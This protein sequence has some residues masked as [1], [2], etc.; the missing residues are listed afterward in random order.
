[1]QETR[2][3]ASR[4]RFALSPVALVVASLL[5]PLAG[6]AQA[7]EA[8]P[9][10]KPSPKLR[11]DIPDAARNQLP[12]FVEGD[13]ISGQTDV[14]T[15]IEGGAELRRGDTV[16][17]ADRMEYHQSDDQARARGNVRINK[18]GNIFEGPLLE[19]KVDAF[20]GFFNEP[21]YRFLR[22]NAYGEADRVD[23]IDDKRAIIRNASYTTC[24]RKPGP[25]WMPDWILRAASI[26][27]DEEEET[28]QA[29]GA[30]LSFMGLPIL[31]VPTMSF[32]L[33]DKRKSGVLPPT[34][35][36]DNVSGIELTLP[37]YWNIAPNRDATL[38]PR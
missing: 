19:L 9:R 33:S 7:D 11:E 25:S 27:I 32:P 3:Q 37:Y 8:S 15:V 24:Q 10:L 1:M 38:Y 35:G 14:N 30:V 26:R 5:Q 13:R 17:R 16:I 21:R 23:F 6:Y 4:A 29:T 34:F 22:N 31:P 12:I 20:E 36:L 2:S 28:G 18:A